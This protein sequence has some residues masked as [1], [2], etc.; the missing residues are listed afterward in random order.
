MAGTENRKRAVENSARGA[1]LRRS[2]V[3]GGEEADA[4][5]DH[6]EIDQLISL[7]IADNPKRFQ[8]LLDALDLLAEKFS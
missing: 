8:P 5:V 6:T 1:A 7:G 2:C 3:R 4:L